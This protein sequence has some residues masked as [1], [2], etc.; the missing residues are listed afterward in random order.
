MKSA[1]ADIHISV[2]GSELN[3]IFLF[4]FTRSIR[5]S[6]NLLTNADT[7]Y[8]MY[9]ALLQ[10]GKAKAYKP[11]YI[12]FDWSTGK[13]TTKPKSYD[14]STKDVIS[15]Q[16]LLTWLSNDVQRVLDKSN[17]KYKVYTE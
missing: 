10:G 2:T 12:V 3:S 16:E 7:K 1:N 11:N 17:G 4:R 5:F 6:A 13:M 15:G 14:S 9:H 8:A